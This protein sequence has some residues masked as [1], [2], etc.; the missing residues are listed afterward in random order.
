MC[1]YVIALY[2]LGKGLVVRLALEIV[3][4]NDKATDIRQE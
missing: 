3:T 4:W 1:S 2:V